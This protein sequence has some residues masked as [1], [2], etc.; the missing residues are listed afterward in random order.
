MANVLLWLCDMVLWIISTST[1]EGNYTEYLMML[2]LC[3]IINVGVFLMQLEWDLILIITL[4]KVYWLLYEWITLRSTMLSSW[5]QEVVLFIFF[6]SQH[7]SMKILLLV[8]VR[9]GGLLNQNLI[10]FKKCFLGKSWLC[11]LSSMGKNTSVCWTFNTI[12]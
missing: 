1:A 3:E 2:I 9:G 11:V 8:F 6:S 7:G 10:N 4:A 12:L 5:R